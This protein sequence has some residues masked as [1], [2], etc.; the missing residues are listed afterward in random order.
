MKKFILAFAVLLGGVNAARADFVIGTDLVDAQSG[1]ELNL[2]LG[3]TS[4]LEIWVLGEESQNIRGVNFNMGSDAPGIVN[5]SSLLIDDLNNRWPLN[6]LGGN[7]PDPTDDSANGLLVNDAQLATIG[8]FVG[9]GVTFTAAEPAVRLGTIDISADTIG[10]ANIE[11]TPGPNGVLD[12]TG[13]I[14]GFVTGSRVFNV[15]SIT[16]I[17]EPS[18]LIALSMMATVGLV[19][20]RRR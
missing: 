3:T 13:A 15:V 10:T 9:T 8:A 18:S 5:S 17:P 11:F 2:E 20:R 7:F 4:T 12:Q 6:N 1:T 19:R 16:A 14:T